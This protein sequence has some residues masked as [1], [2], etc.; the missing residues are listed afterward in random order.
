[1]ACETWRG[2][3]WFELISESRRPR[4]EPDIDNVPHEFFLWHARRGGG[5][6]GS[7]VSAKAA[8]QDSNQMMMEAPGGEG[9]EYFSRTNYLFRLGG[10]R[11]MSN[12]ITC[13]YTIELKYSIYSMQSSRIFFSLHPPPPSD[14]M[15]APL[16]HGLLPPYVHLRHNLP[17]LTFFLASVCPKHDEMLTIKYTYIGVPPNLSSIMG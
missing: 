7:N 13:L 17:T 9:L 3:L 10:V 2:S 15:V 5:H 4:F 11:K 14:W 1:M 16:G 12:F 8:V 6:S